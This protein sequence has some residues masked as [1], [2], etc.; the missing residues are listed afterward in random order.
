MAT[1]S[2][3]RNSLS[4]W[5]DSNLL[6]V[7][8][9][10]FFRVE[11]SQVDLSLRCTQN[12]SIASMFHQIKKVLNGNLTLLL[13]LQNLPIHFSGHVLQSLIFVSVRGNHSC[14]GR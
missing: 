5:I 2:L 11:I 10:S 12:F 13:Q 4:C 7:N 3:I 8:T 6:S 9:S 14:Q 1:N